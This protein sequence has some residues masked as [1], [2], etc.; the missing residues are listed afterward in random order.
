[1]P[2]EGW[3]RTGAGIILAQSMSRQLGEG[4]CIKYF[5]FTQI[6]EAMFFDNKKKKKRWESHW[7][8][9]VEQVYG[10]LHP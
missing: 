2:K 1:M 7:I 3:G 8:N 9:E 6:F 5:Q 4:A 10:H